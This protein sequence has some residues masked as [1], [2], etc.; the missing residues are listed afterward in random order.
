MIK[1]S[2][3]LC[4]RN[5]FML[6]ALSSLV[7]LPSAVMVMSTSATSPSS[8]EIYPP[9]SMAPTEADIA[10]VYGESRELELQFRAIGG[11]IHVTNMVSNNPEW[12]ADDTNFTV[13]TVYY[14][15]V[16][17]TPN[18]D[19]GVSTASFTVHTDEPSGIYTFTVSGARVAQI[20]PSMVLFSMTSISL[21]KQLR[22]SPAKDE[23]Y[24]RGTNSTPPPLPPT[25]PQGRRLIRLNTTTRQETAMVE[26]PAEIN[27]YGVTKDG[28]WLYVVTDDTLYTMNSGTFQIVNTFSPTDI[29][30]AN[31]TLHHIGVFSNTLAYIST[32]PGYA[33]GGPVYKWN[34]QTNEWG[35]SPL[36]DSATGE[37]ARADLQVSGDYNTIGGICDPE[38]SPSTAFLYQLGGTVETWKSEIRY[39]SGISPDGQ[40]IVSTTYPDKWYGNLRAN[41]RGASGNMH[42]HTT[43]SGTILPSIVFR[44]GNWAYAV[45][46]S[47]ATIVEVDPV[48]AV[49]TRRIALTRPEP[50][51]GDIPYPDGLVVKDNWLY[52]AAWIMGPLGNYTGGGIVAVYLDPPEMYRYTLSSRILGNRDQPVALATVQAVPPALNTSLSDAHGNAYLYF[53]EERTY[54]IQTVRQGFGSLPSMRNVLVTGTIGAVTTFYLPPADDQ[55]ADGGFESGGAVAWRFYGEVTPTVITTAHT[56]GY[57]ASLGGSIPSEASESGPWESTIEQEIVFSPTLLTS[58]TL[59]L[60]YRIVAA[61]PAIDTLQAVLMEPAQS[62]TYTLPLTTSGW[63][64]KWWDLSA[65][66]NPTM[67][68]RLELIQEGSRDRTVNILVDEI[69]LGSAI[70]GAYPVCLPLALRNSP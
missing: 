29:N 42:I 62:V 38:Y 46:S 47:P 69:S 2:S 45:S 3:M 56:G 27:D 36:C 15:D 50:R 64:H 7:L 55:V 17:F 33:S 53:N 67:T 66:D 4:F 68:L 54:E 23:L 32:N 16:V 24:A 9:N 22:P 31:A 34:P 49:Q 19:T 18:S 41:R 63:T 58:G 1:S 28:Q 35:A 10:V 51:W 61:D 37:G 12:I 40:W 13:K 48:C 57:A 6:G 44:P 14:P 60:L 25:D 5:K 39:D 65:W 70:K 59:S 26:L 43:D 20:S 21:P 11:E 30:P 8:L 52:V